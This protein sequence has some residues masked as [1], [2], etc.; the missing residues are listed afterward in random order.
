MNILDREI[1]EQSATGKIDIDSI[2]EKV[3]LQSPT[4]AQAAEIDLE[5]PLNAEK[6]EFY[7]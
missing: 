2:L 1:L 7:K 5:V 3:G 6:E 4:R